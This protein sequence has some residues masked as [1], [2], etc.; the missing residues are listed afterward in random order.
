[1]APITQASFLTFLPCI[2]LCIMLLLCFLTVNNMSVFERCLLFFGKKSKKYLI[3]WRKSRKKL[4]FVG[5]RGAGLFGV[6]R[7]G[8]LISYIIL[9][10]RNIKYPPIYTESSP[11]PLPPISHFPPHIAPYYLRFPRKIKPKNI[12]NFSKTHQLS[13]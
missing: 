7:W 5:L 11:T 12:K 13:A 2:I 8:V 3:I 9:N 4:I 1:M 10:G 6:K